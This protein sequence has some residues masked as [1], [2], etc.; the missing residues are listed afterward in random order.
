VWQR[1]K[2]CDMSHVGWCV[3]G[4]LLVLQARTVAACKAVIL[5]SVGCQCMPAQCALLGM[6]LCDVLVEHCV[7]G[8]IVLPV[9]ALCGGGCVR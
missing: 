5:R 4:V 8:R 3:S 9:R 1:S 6:W 7:L 2:L